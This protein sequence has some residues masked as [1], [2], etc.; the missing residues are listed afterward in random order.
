M[1]LPLRPF[2]LSLA[3]SAIAMAV[4]ALGAAA[5]ECPAPQVMLSVDKSYSMVNSPLS[6]GSSKWD[7]ARV[8][9]KNI[10]RKH[11]DAVDFGVHV[12]PAVNDACDSG[13]VA[14]P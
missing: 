4:L 6:D 8:A 3:V 13:T 1:K 10:V 5:Q 14:L 11:S 12:F 2:L 9:I 7:G